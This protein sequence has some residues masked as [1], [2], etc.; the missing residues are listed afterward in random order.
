M[1]LKT[2]LYLSPKNQNETIS[3]I[4]YDILQGDLI[5]KTKDEKYFSIPA[6]QLVKFNNFQFSL[7][8]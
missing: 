8:L 4:G 1:F 2:L 5:S 6:D 7:D 3:V